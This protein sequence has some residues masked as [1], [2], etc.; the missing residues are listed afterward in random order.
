MQWRFSVNFIQYLEKKKNFRHHSKVWQ[1]FVYNG[2]EIQRKTKINI[3]ILFSLD[4]FRF[5]CLP[6]THY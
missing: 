5:F 6:S 4:Y 3:R 2:F 1:K